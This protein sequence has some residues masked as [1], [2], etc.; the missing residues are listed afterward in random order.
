MGLDCG[1]SCLSLSLSELTPSL[2]FWKV[3]FWIRRLVY[4]SGGKPVARMPQWTGALKCSPSL[5]YV[6]PMG[7]AS[8]DIGWRL[9]TACLA[10]GGWAG[11]HRRHRSCSIHR[12]HMCCIVVCVLH[13]FL[14]V[15]HCCFA[16][17]IHLY[18]CTHYLISDMFENFAFLRNST[19]VFEAEL[20]FLLY[21]IHPWYVL[22]FSFSCGLLKI[23]KFVIQT[24]IL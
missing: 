16:C 8:S 19:V 20:V 14:K 2:C 7:P 21:I 17:C 10:I 22:K 3:Y 13:R 11:F 9:E 24:K 15:S 12:L 5:I 6:I 23:R 1:S 18:T 4:V